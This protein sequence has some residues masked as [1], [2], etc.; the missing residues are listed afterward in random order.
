MTWQVLSALRRPEAPA[1]IKTI[2]GDGN[3][4]DRDSRPSDLQTSEHNSANAAFE[5]SCL[6]CGR[7]IKG[8]ILEQVWQVRLTG[9]QV[10]E[11]CLLS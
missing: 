2:T 1:L 5:D 10:T 8:S 9:R 11:A 6:R 4:H 7:L 3:M